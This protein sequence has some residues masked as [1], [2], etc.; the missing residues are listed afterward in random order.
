MMFAAPGVAGT[1]VSIEIKETRRGKQ[2]LFLE[3]GMVNE[4]GMPALMS[5]AVFGTLASGNEYDIAYYMKQLETPVRQLLGVVME[6]R[7]VDEM[8]RT[9]FQQAA[10]KQKGQMSLEESF[11]MKKQKVA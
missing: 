6:P 2:F 3:A 5:R 9:F 4:K 7:M 11:G 1:T 8:F 10:N